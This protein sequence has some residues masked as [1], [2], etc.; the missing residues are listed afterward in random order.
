MI[1]ETSI[2]ER[3]LLPEPH[4]AGAFAAG[5]DEMFLPGTDPD[6]CGRRADYARKVRR[7]RLKSL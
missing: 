5:Q 2:L 1:A 4:D 7:L 3:Q 6:D